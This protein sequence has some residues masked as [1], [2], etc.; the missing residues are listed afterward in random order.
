MLDITEFFGETSGG[1]RTYLL[2]KARYVEA[3]PWLRQVLLVPGPE[4]AIHA[5][6]GVRCYRLRGP[7][8]PT[9]HPYRFM[10]ATRSTSRV[11]A[12]EHP[13]LIEVGSTWLVPWLIRSAN[14]ELRIPTVWFYHSH[15]PRIVAPHPAKAGWARRTASATAWRYVRRLGRLVGATLAPCE[16]VARELEAAG[17][18]RVCRVSLGVD[19]ERFHPSRRLHAES[20]RRRFGLPDGPLALY[21]G[22]FAREKDLDVLL[23]AWRDVRARTGA[24]LALVGDGP[25]REWL[26]RQPGAAGVLWLPFERD[27]DRLAD[28]MAAVDLYIAPSPT[29]TFGLAAHEALASGVPVIAAEPGGVAE[30]VQRS[31][32]GAVFPA[33]DAGALAEVT[34]A[35]FQS[36][37][38]AFGARGR[39]YVEENHGW[40]TVFDRLFAVY[41]GVL[42]R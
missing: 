41:R 13:N 35:I 34:T 5:T 4:D 11:V 22:R 18:E 26:R 33:G 15:F 3:R 28:L 12:H 39:A 14:R 37:L 20:T 30:S 9:Q 1:V 7:A 40:D 38:H 25:S 32:A 21:V 29:E 8:I 42:A 2:Q 36:D 27:R 23:A 24:T 16:G 6:D 31:A 10:L 17:V 19:L